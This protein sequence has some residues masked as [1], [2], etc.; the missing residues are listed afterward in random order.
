MPISQ[1]ETSQTRSSLSRLQN[2]NIAGSTIYFGFGM[3]SFRRPGRSHVA[4]EFQNEPPN[5]RMI[6]KLCEYAS[7]N[8]LR[9]PKAIVC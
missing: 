3:S 4:T 7:K 8:P 5:D 1:Q 9:I 6:N 2:L